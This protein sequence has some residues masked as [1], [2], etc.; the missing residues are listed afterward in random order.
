LAILNSDK[1]KELNIKTDFL[2]EGKW[3]L[4]VAKDDAEKQKNILTE[5]RTVDAGES[6]S[7]HLNSNGGYVA[8]FLKQ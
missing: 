6:L 2:K 3:R 5:I 8:Q 1:S 4:F 7:I